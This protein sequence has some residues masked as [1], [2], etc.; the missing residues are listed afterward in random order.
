MTLS[1]VDPMPANKVQGNYLS[2]FFF[3]AKGYG[4]PEAVIDEI[5]LQVEQVMTFGKYCFP[6]HGAGF[7]L[8]CGGDESIPRN[9]INHLNHLRLYYYS[10]LT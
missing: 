10:F 4:E 1:F 7:T 8:N 3:S 9:L 2:Y 5:S 6:S